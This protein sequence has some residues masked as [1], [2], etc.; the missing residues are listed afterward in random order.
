MDYNFKTDYNAD[1]TK[2]SYDKVVNNDSDFSSILNNQ[3]D[4]T[5][6]FFFILK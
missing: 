1:I 6:R 2:E 4:D 5:F 3:I